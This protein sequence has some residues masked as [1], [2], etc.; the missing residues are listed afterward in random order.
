MG[1]MSNPSVNRW[2]LNTFWYKFWYS[3]KNY[4]LNRAQD[5]I[6]TKLVHTYLFY[7]LHF[8]KN[9]FWNSYWFYTNRPKLTTNRY[10]RWIPARQTPF[11]ISPGYHVR[12]DIRSSYDIYPMKI[13]ILRYSRWFIFNFYWFQPF[14]ANEQRAAKAKIRI[15]D[16]YYLVKQPETTTTRRIKTLVSTTMLKALRSRKVYRF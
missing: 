10:F 9:I 12:A 2:G 16:H 11:G 8:F 3:D 6:F 5:D 14:K 4:A 1:N 15:A 13:W 7:G